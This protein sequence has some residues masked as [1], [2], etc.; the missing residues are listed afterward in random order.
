MLASCSLVWSSTILTS[1]L[2]YENFL[3][4][5][6]ILLGLPAGGTAGVLLY[7]RIIHH[8]RVTARLLLLSLGFGLTAA[9][10]LVGMRLLS[11]SEDCPRW[12]IFL[13]RDVFIV[14]LFVAVGISCTLGHAVAVSKAQ[15][16]ST[17]GEGRSRTQP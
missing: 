13:R 14:I 15:A 12:L 8:E 11:E 6:I 2:S 5:G 9:T 3:V 10:M 1:V 4:F 16:R 7:A 17:A